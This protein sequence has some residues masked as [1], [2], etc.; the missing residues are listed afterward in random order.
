LTGKEGCRGEH[1]EDRESTSKD[2]ENSEVNETLRFKLGLKEGGKSTKVRGFT[3]ET[4]FKKKNRRGREKKNKEKFG[5]SRGTGSLRHARKKK[6]KGNPRGGG[7]HR[8]KKFL[9]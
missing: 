4:E 5:R 8:P 9:T 6:K 7:R 1:E 2:R 3:A